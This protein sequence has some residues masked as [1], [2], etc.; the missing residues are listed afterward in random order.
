MEEVV[1][2]IP[3]Q[4]DAVHLHEKVEELQ[5]RCMLLERNNIAQ[6]SHIDFLT[7]K[8]YSLCHSTFTTCD[9]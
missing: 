4:N 3:E 5:Q 6:K 9:Y 2:Q 1:I 8:V 7:Q